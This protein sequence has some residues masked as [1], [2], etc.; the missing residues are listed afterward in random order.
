MALWGVGQHRAAA[1]LLGFGPALH[2]TIGVWAIAVT[3]LVAAL[4]RSFRALMAAAVPWFLAGA[5]AALASAAVHLF[6]PATTG[7]IA[8][9]PSVSALGAHWDEHRQP[10]P[11]LGRRALAAYFAAAVPALWVVRY[12]ADVAPHA[13]LLLRLLVVSAAIGAA[14][15]VSYWIVPP[16]VPSLVATLMPSRLLNL[17]GTAC[18]ALLLGLSPRYTSHRLVRSALVVMVV[19]LVGLAAALGRDDDGTNQELVAWGAMALYAILL[20]IVAERRRRTPATS[21]PAPWP[22]TR[23]RIF[24]I[25]A[26]T[27]AL[28]GV[29]AVAS[30]EFG[31]AIAVRLADRTSD[32]VYAAAARRRGLLLTSSSL[33]LVQLATRRP[34]LLDG[35]AIDALLYVPDAVPEADRIL[36]RVYGID[37]QQVRRARR[38]YLGEET[39]RTLWESRTPDEWS[40]VANEFG[41]TDVLTDATWRLQLPIVASNAE[42]VLYDIP[43]E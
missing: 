4:D 17:S 13:R 14:L 33:H 1:V 42:L 40:A 27:A 25:G 39:G 18:M 29:A 10:F 36:Q 8:P 21:S 34:V 32:D 30:S 3:A 7:G 35:R 26:I 41:V 38:G 15:S 19:G 6:H 28:V 2:V 37:F 20:A 22:R 31:R 5:A 16:D 23:V 24:T 9:L 12:A 43:N 11:L